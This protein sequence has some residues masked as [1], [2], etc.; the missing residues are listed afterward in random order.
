MSESHTLELSEDGALV[1]PDAIRHQ[2]SLQP[3]DRFILTLNPDGTLHLT[4]LRSQLRSLRGIFKDSAADTNLSDELIRD[5]RQEA[6][7]ENQP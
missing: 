4:N 5:R 2:L 3:G 1:L 7:Q 6:Q